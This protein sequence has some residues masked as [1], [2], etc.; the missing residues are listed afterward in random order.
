MGNN[1][2]RQNLAKF[3]LK[4][5]K[6]CVIIDLPNIVNKQTSKLVNKQTNGSVRKKTNRKKINKGF[7][8]RM[9]VKTLIPTSNKETLKTNI[10]LQYIDLE[11]AARYLASLFFS[12]NLKDTKS[13]IHCTLPKVEKLLAITAI[14]QYKKG[15]GIFY[16]DILIKKCGVGF[17]CLDWPSDIIDMRKED[18]YFNTGETNLSIKENVIPNTVTIP[19]LY[20]YSE[21]EQLPADICQL[22]ESVFWRFANYKASFLG[23]MIDDFKMNIC[24]E[25][26]EISHVDIYKVLDYFSEIDDMLNGKN[27]VYDFILKA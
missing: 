3:V 22:L 21:S 12:Y 24:I 10:M 6:L 13:A 1:K 17:D 9:P 11:S 8:K 26:D 14:I 15:V 18:D 19:K 4:N 25:Q 5:E 7:V 27:E 23:A 16:E 20:S 2:K